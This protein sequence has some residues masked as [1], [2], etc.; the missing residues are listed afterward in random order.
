MATLESIFGGKNLTDMVQG[1]KSD[2]PLSVPEAALQPTDLLSGRTATWPVIE[3][4]RAIAE[5]VAYGSPA[6]RVGLQGVKEASA[7]MLHSFESQSYDPNK[8]INLISTDGQKQQMGREWLAMQ[9]KEFK[10]R[11][12]RL[13]QQT[14][15]AMLLSGK[16]YFNEKGQLLPSDS[17]AITTVDAG[18]AAGHLNQLDILGSGSIISASWAT[19][20]TDIVTQLL[21][22]QEQMLQDGGWLVTECY[23]GKNIPKYI[24]ANNTAKEWINNNETLSRQ[25]FAAN[26]VPEGFQGF[27]WHYAGNAYWIDAGGTVRKHVG[28]DEIVFMPTIDKTWYRMF[29]GSV[30]VP[31]GVLGPGQSLDQIVGSI[32]EAYGIFSYAAGSH[33]PV[34]IEQFVGATFLPVIVAKKAW[35]KADVTP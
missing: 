6:K 2:I 1:V 8:L 20:S 12:V 3:S 31:T 28:D 21:T 7:T 10:Q 26:R 19:A 32:M 16:I 5:I 25:A 17:G 14:V 33:N 22:I 24:F 30:A 13:I 15:Q 9:T 23:Y 35:A 34:S 11:I 29:H 18:I 4:N 27:N